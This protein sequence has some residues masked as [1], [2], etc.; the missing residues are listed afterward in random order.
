M[1][2]I[3]PLLQSGHSLAITR[4]LTDLILHDPSLLDE[5]FRVLLSDS[6]ILKQRAAWVLGHVATANPDLFKPFLNDVIALTTD[7]SHPAI[8]RNALKVLE[9]TATFP[10]KH[11]SKLIDT[12]FGI[13]QDRNEPPAIRVYAM[14]ILNHLC[15]VYP[16]LSFELQ[17]IIEDELPHA[18]A[19]FRSRGNKILKKLQSL[20]R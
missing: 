4:Q 9:Q 20:S 13:L 14:S 1:K 3:I 7:N 5:L 2:P 17:A 11:H 18:S 19:G 6:V 8:K 15:N 16:D 10:K 12:C